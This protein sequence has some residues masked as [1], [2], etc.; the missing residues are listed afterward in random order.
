MDDIAGKLEAIFMDCLFRKEEREGLLDGAVPANTVGGQGILHN[1]G[2]HRE[3]LESH[4]ADVV[5]IIAEM[6]D[7]FF[8]DLGGGGSFLMLCM[9]RNGRQWG[10][11]RNAE[12]LLALATA[13]RLGIILTPHEFWQD[14]PGGVPYFRFLHG[15]G[16]DTGMNDNGRES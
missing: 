6:R 7:E 1:F 9:D 14:M 8:P 5:R 15:E 13:L 12:Q 3:R 10:E 16:E 11:H 4:R 2:F